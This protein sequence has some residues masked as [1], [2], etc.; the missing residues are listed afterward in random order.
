MTDGP[1]R[2]LRLSKADFDSL[3]LSGN[4]FAFQIVDLASRQL[5][6]HLRAANELV[7]G[8]GRSAALGPAPSGH[9]KGEASEPEIVPLEL[10]L[11]MEVAAGPT[12]GS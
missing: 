7:R 3:F 5:V 11:E 2:L 9:S 4:R 12:A 6:A 1:A 8:P 10:E